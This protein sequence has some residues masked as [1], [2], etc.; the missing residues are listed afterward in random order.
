MRPDHTQ[1]AR[2]DEAGNTVGTLPLADKAVEYFNVVG[3]LR[4]P[5]VELLSGAGSISEQNEAGA[6]TARP[7]G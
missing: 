4:W 7:E 5:N 6:H 1:L 3:A 2:Q